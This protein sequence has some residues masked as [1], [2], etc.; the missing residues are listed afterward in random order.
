[1]SASGPSARAVAAT[2]LARVTDEGAF[3][4][5]ALDAELSRAD[6]P[7]RDAALVTELVYGTLRVLPEL[8]RAIAAHLHRPEQKLDAR[9]RAALRL[10]AYQLAHMPR[11]PL[12]SAVDESVRTVTLLRGPRLAGVANA[13]LRKLAAAHAQ[14]V[15]APA[16]RMA[17][18]P[19]LHEEL[20]AAL[21]ATR[22]EALL[23]SLAEAP[24]LCLRVHGDLSREQLAA[25][26]QK[27]R[28]D[29]AITLGELSPRALLLRRAG[30]PRKLPGYA[31]GRFAVQ[32]E[33]AQLVALALGAQP[34]ERVADLCAGH[35]GKTALLAQLV[36]A[37]GRVLAVDLDERKLDRLEH[38]LT[39]LSVTDG[40]VER[41][42]LDLAVGVGGLGPDFDRVLVDAPCTGLGTL[43]RRPELLLRI[44]PHDPERMAGLQLAILRN[45]ARLVRPGG[46]L[47]FAVCSFTRAE[48]PALAARLE[49]AEPSLSRTWQP[50]PELAFL[51][52]DADG[53]CRLGP[54][55]GSTER[56]SPDAYQLAAF[57]K[58]G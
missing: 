4:S 57:T 42:S 20:L 26:L 28:S 21:G 16:E 51:P 43:R 31:E 9:L 22:A 40:R 44:Q 58:R 25:E 29:A 46:Q 30:D 14:G 34:G 53:M 38:E 7:A 5:A 2:V 19:W 10:G 37:A 15:R 1:M 23:A 36:G 17:L 24:P 35:G 11:V 13:V 32:E 18:P 39:R 33:G 50:P 6:L 47:V 49:A 41:R 8:D 56:G 48:G 45:A 55:L 12:H 3:A 54:W 52:A 27:A